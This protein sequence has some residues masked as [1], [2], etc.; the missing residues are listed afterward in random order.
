MGKG[1]AGLCES[2]ALIRAGV[3]DS[4]SPSRLEADEAKL[5]ADNLRTGNSA[6]REIRLEVA[7]SRFKPTGLTESG[8]DKSDASHHSAISRNMPGVASQINRAPPTLFRRQSSSS[9]MQPAFFIS[10]T[11]R[12]G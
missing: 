9:P 5:G 10:I 8:S 11:P 3:C 6:R 2:G 1:R 12:G 4:G 7:L